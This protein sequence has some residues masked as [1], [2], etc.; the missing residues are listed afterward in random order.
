MNRTLILAA[1]LATALAGTTAQAA[2]SPAPALGASSSDIQMAGVV[3]GPGFHLSGLVCVRNGVAPM[4]AKVCP[5][6]WHLGP[7]GVCR[8]N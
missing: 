3:C 8:R 7:A 2:M 5:V 1:A 6:G 4:R